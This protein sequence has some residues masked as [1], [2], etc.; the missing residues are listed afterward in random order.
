MRGQL[1]TNPDEARE[2]REARGRAE[3][4]GTSFMAWPNLAYV[5]AKSELS[6]PRELNIEATDVE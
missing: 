1:L 4:E 3:A 2:W 6:A 5:G